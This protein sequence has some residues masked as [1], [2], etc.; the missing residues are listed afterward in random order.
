M[1]EAAS[2]ASTVNAGLVYAVAIAEA[3][4][5]I[6]LSSGSVPGVFAA[7]VESATAGSAQDATVIGVIVGAVVRR[8]LRPMHQIL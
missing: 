8:R 6:D 2:A 4:T 5:A 7:T 3:V 1:I